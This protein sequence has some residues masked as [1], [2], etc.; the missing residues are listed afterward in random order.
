MFVLGFLGGVVFTIAMAGLL[1][2]ITRPWTL[3]NTCDAVLAPPVSE[4]GHAAYGGSL[5]AAV[6]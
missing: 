6:K 1:L 2:V 4:E 5:T 3:K